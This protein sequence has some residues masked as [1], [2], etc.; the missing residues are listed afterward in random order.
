[1]YRA[2]T[3]PLYTP[4][5][6][7]RAMTGPLYTPIYMYRAMT[8]PLYTSIYMYRAMTGPLG[9][10]HF[11]LGPRQHNVLGRCSVTVCYLS[12]NAA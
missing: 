5:Y 9:G 4:I 12:Q 11:I 2:M 1:M 8:G 10:Q 3:C 6:M 7:Y